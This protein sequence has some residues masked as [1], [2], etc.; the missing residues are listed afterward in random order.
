[1][2]KTY[3]DHVTIPVVRDVL[4]LRSVDDDSIAD[5]LSLTEDAWAKDANN[6]DVPFE[7]HNLRGDHL[8][9]ALFF[10]NEEGDTGATLQALREYWSV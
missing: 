4:E 7:V 9:N 1:M 3:F 8:G 10:W 2:I 5:A 6:E